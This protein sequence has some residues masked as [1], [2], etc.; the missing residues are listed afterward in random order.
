MAA[1]HHTIPSPEEAWVSRFW[2]KVDRTDDQNSCWEWT[3]AGD[4]EGY[5]HFKISGR[6]YRAARVSYFLSTGDQPG[7]RLILHSCDNPRC[8]N[9]IHLRAGTAA[10][11]AVDMKTRNRSARLL[12]ETNSAAKLTETDVLWIRERH[13][14]SRV[15][16]ASTARKFGVSEGLIGCII[17]RENWQHLP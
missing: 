14:H 11:N 3:A 7:G 1:A 10:D 4:R 9:P 5:G 15:S 8:V 2:S 16:Y 17:R 12:G 13:K 6:Q